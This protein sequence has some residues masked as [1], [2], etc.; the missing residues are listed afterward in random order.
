MSGP[1]SGRFINPYLATIPESTLTTLISPWDIL[2]IIKNTPS[3]PRDAIHLSLHPSR[4]CFE[5]RIT[6]HLNQFGVVNKTVGFMFSPFDQIVGAAVGLEGAVDKQS[7]QRMH[8]E[9]NTRAAQST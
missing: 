3:I 8:K 9:W 4:S 7:I 1:A 5:H 2:P 6:V